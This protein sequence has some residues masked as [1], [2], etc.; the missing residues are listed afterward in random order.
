MVFTSKQVNAAIK[1]K[2][3]PALRAA[4]FD[5]FDP[6]NGWRHRPESIAVVNFQSFNAYKAGTLGCTTFSFGVNA[7]VYYPCVHDTP[8]AAKWP[9]FFQVRP[10]DPPESGCHARRQLEKRVSQPD[11]PRP[12]IWYVRPDG[13]NLGAVIDD[14][15]A[16]IV[17]VGLPWLDAFGDLSHALSEYRTPRQVGRKEYVCAFGTEKAADEGSAVAFALGDLDAARSLWQAVIDSPYYA[18]FPE[19]LAKARSILSSIDDA[20]V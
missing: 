1:E 2:V 10:A 15:V 18:R 11:Y 7:A 3:R 4:G 8:W 13:E 9:V 6:R 5:K 20:A 12:D 14:A 16:A 19:T 17:D